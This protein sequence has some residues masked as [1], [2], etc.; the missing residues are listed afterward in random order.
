MGTVSDTEFA[1]LHAHYA[2]GEERARLDSAVGQVEFDRTVEMLLDWLP[3]APTLSEPWVS[4]LKSATRE[5]ARKDT[6]SITSM[7]VMPD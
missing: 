2:L 7:S 5:T 3:P 1:G 4:M 6:A